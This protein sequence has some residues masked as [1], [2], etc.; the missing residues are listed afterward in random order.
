MPAI[1]EGRVV[2]FGSL[3]GPHWDGFDFT[4]APVEGG[5]LFF[6]LDGDMFD[7]DGLLGYVAP[8]GLYLGQNLRSL[9]DPGLFLG[10]T[11]GMVGLYSWGTRSWTHG[12]PG[13]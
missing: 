4:I 5:V 8:Q 6:D 12:C 7:A 11:E 13:T 3:S 1:V 10:D 2:S 9:T